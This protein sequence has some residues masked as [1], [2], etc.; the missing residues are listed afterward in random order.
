MY[1]VDVIS[2]SFWVVQFGL[3]NGFPIRILPSIP[4]IQTQTH[5]ERE[6]EQLIRFYLSIHCT[7]V[8]SV[9]STLYTPQVCA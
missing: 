6:R 5:A 4:H 3:E 7:S 1:S 8:Q 9:Q 2:F